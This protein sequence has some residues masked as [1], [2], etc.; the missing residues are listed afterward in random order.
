MCSVSASWNLRFLSIQSEILQNIHIVT[1]YPHM[2]LKNVTF[3]S[4]TWSD[5]YSW[6]LFEIFIHRM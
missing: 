6:I 3:D 5:F 4:I 1:K 2:P